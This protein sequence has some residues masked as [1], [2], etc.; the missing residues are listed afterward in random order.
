MKQSLYWAGVQKHQPAPQGV[1]CPQRSTQELKSCFWKWVL[2]LGC[3]SVKRCCAVANACTSWHLQEQGTGGWVW[4]FMKG[5][6]ALPE[7]WWWWVRSFCCPCVHKYAE[8]CVTSLAH[9]WWAE[10]KCC[11]LNWALDRRGT[12]EL[13]LNSLQNTDSCSSH[14][15]ACCCL[16]SNFQFQA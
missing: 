4:F 13:A 8:F 3:P 12:K 16:T 15:I 1:V 14:S 2:C 9:S 6:L 11:L 10:V 5:C 7:K